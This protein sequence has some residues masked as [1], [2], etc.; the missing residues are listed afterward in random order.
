M[1]QRRPVDNNS[2]PPKLRR[3]STTADHLNGT[4]MSETCRCF[5]DMALTSASAT[6][7]RIVIR[8]ARWFATNG[9]TKVT[10]AGTITYSKRY[11][12]EARQDTFPIPSKLL[13]FTPRPRLPHP[14]KRPLYFNNL[15]YDYQGIPFYVTPTRSFPTAGNP[16]GTWL[17]SHPRECLPSRPPSENERSCEVVAPAIGGR[18]KCDPG[19]GLQDWL[20]PRNVPNTLIA[21]I[22]LENCRP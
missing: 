12:T 6:R 7:D 10:D 21:F 14:S 2:C 20:K 16:H 15:R 18:H 5:S 3:E 13:R 17:S 8:G 11:P 4:S 9:D 22:R 19:R 1:R